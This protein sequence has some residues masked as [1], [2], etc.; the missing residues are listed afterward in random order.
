MTTTAHAVHRINPSTWNAGFAFDQ[1]QLRP[2][3]QRLL[4]LAGQGPISAEGELLHA[5]DM[6]GQLSA[7]FGCVED[8]LDR[9]GMDLGDV[10]SMTVYVTDMDAALASYAAVADRLRAAG[11]TPPATVVEVTRLAV[12]GMQVEIAVSA[13]R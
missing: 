3:P 6:A 8:L 1:A 7:A 9:G 2:F 10:L 13:G 5:G 4:T 11:A 12:P